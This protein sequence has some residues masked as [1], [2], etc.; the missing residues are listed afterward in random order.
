MSI[1]NTIR[2]L[3][4][5]ALFYFSSCENPSQKQEEL[6]IDIISIEKSE[7]SGAIQEALI[8]NQT[9]SKMNVNLSKLSDGREIKYCKSCKELKDAF[10]NQI[11]AYC[12]LNFDIKNAHLG[13]LYNYYAIFDSVG[14]APKGWEI[15]SVNDFETLVKAH[16]EMTKND[17]GQISYVFNEF[18]F[19]APSYTDRNKNSIGFDAFLLGNTDSDYD[20]QFVE[21]ISDFWTNT[22]TSSN[23]EDW[24]RKDEL[25]GWFFDSN[26]TII[27]AR[28]Q[29]NTDENLTFKSE[30]FYLFPGANKKTLMP[31]RLIKER[32]T[33][34]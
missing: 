7:N 30:G 18:S 5:I 26:Q 21:G 10:E 16:G 24:S 8:Q 28:F 19:K 15:P 11:P 14:I 32:K 17:M 22:I 23:P 3:S 29:D 27:M 4:L 2:I 13:K 6:E 20:C 25:K 33:K 9:W 1:K 12:Y 31:L 34:N